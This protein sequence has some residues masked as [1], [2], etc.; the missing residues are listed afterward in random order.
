MKS[1]LSE[2]EKNS[3]KIIT[4]LRRLLGCS[5]PGP[6]PRGGRKTKAEDEIELGLYWW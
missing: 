5:A 4:L 3:T 6:D 1:K 2:K